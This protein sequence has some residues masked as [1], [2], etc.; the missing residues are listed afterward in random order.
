MTPTSTSKAATEASSG[1]EP[2]TPQAGLPRG[3]DAACPVCHGA[4]FVHPLFPSGLPDYSRVVACRCRE[5]QLVKERQRVLEKYSN[6]GHLAHYT[7]STL[8]P[9]GRNGYVAGYAAAY[10]AARGFAEQPSGWLVLVGPAGSGKTHLS[11]AIANE[12]LSAGQQVFYVC[13]ADLLDHLR[14]AFNPS[15]DMSYDDLFEQV[16][17]SAVL[18]LDDF[19]VE[20]ATS[21]WAKQ[22]LEQI[23]NHRYSVRL[24]TVIATDVSP[25]E[26][27]VRF[28]E[29]LLDGEICRMF[30]LG[31]PHAG[32][33]DVPPLPDGLRRETFESF[34]LNRVELSREQQQNLKMA[35]DLAYGFAREPEGW[36]VFQGT[37]G[38][39]K[40]HLA[41]AIANVRI[42][43]GAPVLFL[44]VADLLDYLRSAFGP[45]SRV[46]Y[47]RFFDE[48]KQCPL[49][50]LD[51]FGEQSASP[52]A[53]SKLF[54]LINHR[55]N[56]RLPMVVTTSLSLEEIERRISA[57]FA[58]PQIGTVF[59]IIAPHY[60]V[61]G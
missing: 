16:K 48:V 5:P 22:K 19:R 15:S 33:L 35:Y 29:R 39:G 20:E 46:S 2:V 8:R 14:S 51:D 43:A 55:Y 49:L 40:T 11:C 30:Q 59:N 17:N 1:A 60:S 27:D 23:L 41:A 10:G 4:G 44:V 13:T 7:F 50:I 24:P 31:R 53:K 18:V 28:S 26:M 56:A 6:L 57:R 34:D 58:D 21:P 38:C 36:V 25:A 9:E 52:W 32:G 37:N 61:D 47:S 12:R 45:D 42:A 54:Q 3:V